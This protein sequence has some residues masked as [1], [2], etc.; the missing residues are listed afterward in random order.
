MCKVAAPLR[1]VA[2]SCNL[3]NE[4]RSFRDICIGCNLDLKEK[5]DAAINVNTFEPVVI[6]KQV[7]KEKRDFCTHAEDREKLEMAHELTILR[8]AAQKPKRD[9][10]TS[11][12]HKM[13]VHDGLS[14][15]QACGAE[16][17]RTSTK[18]VKLTKHKF[19]LNAL[20]V[21]TDNK[22]KEKRA[23]F[24][25]KNKETLKH[26]ETRLNVKSSLLMSTSK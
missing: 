14:R 18:Q 8:N 2:L 24:H 25:G 3:D 15:N 4:F 12:D 6:H 13:R 5:C 26:V 19:P 22:G 20:L 9:A 23:F 10:S 16:V 11:A 21:F 17:V 7:V 1:D